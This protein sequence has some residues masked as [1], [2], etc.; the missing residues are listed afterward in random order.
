MIGLGVATVAGAG[1]GNMLG[2]GNG[3]AGKKY[4]VAGMINIWIITIPIAV[5]LLILQNTWGKMYVKDEKVLH[6]IDGTT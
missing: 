2:K 5:I 3:R 4:A 6:L 1:V